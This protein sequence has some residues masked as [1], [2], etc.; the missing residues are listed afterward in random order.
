MSQIELFSEIATIGKL[1]E[2]AENYDAKVFLNELLGSKI[3]QIN[4]GG[5]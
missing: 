1:L 4:I 3:E 5:N 2:T